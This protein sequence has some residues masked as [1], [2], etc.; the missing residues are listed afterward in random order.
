MLFYLF[1]PEDRDEFAIQFMAILIS[2]A[3]GTV[4]DYIVRDKEFYNKKELDERIVFL[5]LILKD[6]INLLL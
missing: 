6:D 5:N 2:R 1:L 3:I 4:R